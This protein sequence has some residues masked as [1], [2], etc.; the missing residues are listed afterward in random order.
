MKTQPLFRQIWWAFCLHLGLVVS[1]CRQ[2]HSW[3]DGDCSVS[4]L[5]HSILKWRIDLWASWR[6]LVYNLVCYW[7]DFLWTDWIATNVKLKNWDWLKLIFD[8]KQYKKSLGKDHSAI[9]S[10]MKISFE[11]SYLR[12]LQIIYIIILN[13][14]AVCTSVFLLFNNT[15]LW[16]Q[17]NTWSLPYAQPAVWIL[18]IYHL[19]KLF[20]GWWIARLRVLF[21]CSHAVIIRAF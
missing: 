3:C 8:K 18:A 21:S 15:K 1:G 13:P 19:G 11:R 9:N 5:V 20:F 7:V 16:L 14:K 10:Q 17:N 12:M 2:Q 4:L 6:V